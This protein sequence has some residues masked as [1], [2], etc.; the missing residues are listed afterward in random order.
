[1]MRR[2]VVAAIQQN[3]FKAKH[4]VGEY[5]IALN[6][7]FVIFVIHAER[8]GKS[9]Y[10]LEKNICIL[11]HPQ[12]SQYPD[13]RKYIWSLVGNTRQCFYIHSV[14]IIGWWCRTYYWLCY[15]GSSFSVQVQIPPSLSSPPARPYITS[16]LYQ[17]SSEELGR[18]EVTMRCTYTESRENSKNK[19][20][21]LKEL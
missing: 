20:G 6:R 19:P 9:Y 16:L 15:C 8:L 1:M 11:L 13:N 3:M 10:L 7:R 17:A 12:G 14:I 5:F 18:T 2:L 4:I 21:K